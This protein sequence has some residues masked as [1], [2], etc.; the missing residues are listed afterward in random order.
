MLRMLPYEAIVSQG[1]R[2]RGFSG[3]RGC[4]V[5]LTAAM[6]GARTLAIP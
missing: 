4:K 1:M 6:V 3:S 5:G 2:V